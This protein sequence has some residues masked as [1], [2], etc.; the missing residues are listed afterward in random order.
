MSEQNERNTIPAEPQPVQEEPMQDSPELHCETPESEKTPRKTLPRKMVLLIAAGVVAV[1][2]IAVVIYLQ[3]TVFSRAV[4]AMLQEY[5]YADN[6]RAPDD[7]YM[8]IDTN[9]YDKDYDELELWQQLT[10]YKKQ[11]DSIKGIQ[12]LNE[13][14]GFSSA[15]YKKM[16]ETTALMGRQSEETGKYRVSWTY[17]PDRGL[18]VLYEKK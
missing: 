11:N 13:R 18:E 5:P 15:V 10:F 3:S 2:A 12:F 6:S 9:P 1:A 4:S 8:E 17:H 7:S 14:F 16:M